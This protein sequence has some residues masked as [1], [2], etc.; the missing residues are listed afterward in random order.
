[1]INLNDYFDPVSIE[2]PDYDFISGPARFSHNIFIHTE[3]N[4][5]QDPEKFRIAILGVPEE[6]NSP[7]IGCEKG[8]EAIRHQLYMLSRVPGK[9]KIIDLGNMKKGETFQDTLI[10][11]SEI[12]SFLIKSNI[13]PVIIGG[14]SSLIGSIDNCFTKLKIHYSLASIDSR[15]DFQPGKN[16]IDSFSYLNRIIYNPGNYL[17]HFSNIGYQIYLNDFQAINRLEK[18]KAD[19]IRLGD[20]RASIHLTEPLLRDTDVAIID[21]SC[22]RQSDAPGT[23]NTSPNGFYGEEIC[24]IARYA[25]ISDSMKIFG[26]FEINPLLD[27][28]SQTSSLAAQILWYFLEGFGQKLDEKKLLSAGETGHFTRY[29]VK[30]SGLDEDLVFIKSNSTE[31]WWFEMKSQNNKTKYVS[32]SYDD[33][34]TA[35]RN[36]VP[37]RWLRAFEKIS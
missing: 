19:L 9:L 7:N 1:M 8:P 17:N 29:H 13:F 25:G 22:V 31:R 16:E 24:L 36:E 2:K 20:A 5:I 23:I 26:L 11:L 15:I 18:R 27:R 32:C 10:G 3:N 6:R 14:N 28:N 12:L 35:N 37:V 4:P 30:V 34:L 21:I 33:Y